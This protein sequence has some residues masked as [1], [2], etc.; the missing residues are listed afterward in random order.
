MR[1]HDAAKDAPAAAKAP[2]AGRGMQAAQLP[3]AIG[4]RA[5]SR[6][7]ARMEASEAVDAFAESLAPGV[8]GAEH[9]VIDTMTAFS[10]D[11]GGFDKVSKD[12]EKKAKAPLPPALEQAPGASSLIPEGWYPGISCS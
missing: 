8:M 4:N 3:Q 7:V 12:Y 5:M 9:R 10:A 1:E 2:A 6:I 11:T